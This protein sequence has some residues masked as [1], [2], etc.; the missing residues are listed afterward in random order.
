MT[1]F[2]TIQLRRDTAADWTSVN[3]VLNQGEMG[4]EYDS[5][6]LKIGD[7]STSWTSL[8]YFAGSGG[9][10]VSSVFGRTG[11]V[12]ATSG[13]YTVSEV[14]G[15]APL[16]SPTF[17]GVPAAPTATTGNNT[18]QIATTAFVHTAVAAGTGSVSSVFGRTGAVTAQLGDYTATQ[19][20][21]LA[22][23]SGGSYPG[24]TTEFLRADQTWAVPAGGGGGSS[25]PVV[26]PS[27][28]TTGATDK[29]NITAALANGGYCQLLAATYY[30]NGPIVMPGS[31][32]VAS[33]LHG[34]QV[35][36]G[37]DLDYYSVGEGVPTGTIIQTTT[38]FAGEAVILM[39]NT[40][41]TSYMTPSL[42][43]FVIQCEPMPAQSG[44]N[45][46]HG[47]EMTGAWSA[48][49]I[50]NVFV[51]KPQ[52]S[53]FLF[54]DATT[55]TGNPDNNIIRAC[56]AAGAKGASGGETGGYGFCIAHMPDAVFSD[57]E[58]SECDLDAWF[59]VGITNCMFSNCKGENS[60]N[61]WH[62]TGWYGAGE[63]A[64]F[65]GCTSNENYNNGWLFDNT[66]GTGLGTYVLSG[67]K[68]TNENQA[69]TTFGGFV[70]SSCQSR[71]LLTG[72]YADQNLHFGASQT[73]S[74]LMQVVGGY[75]A[76]GSAATFNGTGNTHPLTTSALAAF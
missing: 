38:T 20:G 21:A 44:S 13:D 56:K 32:S 30:V 74:Y 14:T 23:P 4:F 48:G 50:Q 1:T 5:G 36:W 68:A 55:G 22:E 71:I 15:A 43:D 3:P 70:A 66:N 51:Y 72:C 35:G 11:A 57:C 64:V 60:T 54:Q 59:T 37:D 47:I 52:G 41:S 46:G 12:T 19:V 61:G 76:G 67:C 26:S 18:T 73:G 24:G 65:T 53:C 29:A 16:A 69:N 45:G 8:A 75:F 2:T 6:K 62:H 31:V 39:N 63:Y 17:T 42:R 27:G 9:G 33:A 25:I 58:A 10:A 28:D 40:S 34:L 49:F 7:G